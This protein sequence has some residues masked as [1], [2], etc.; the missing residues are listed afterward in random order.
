MKIRKS[1]L[2]EE[3]RNYKLQLQLWN[4]KIF[5]LQDFLFFRLLSI[6]FVYHQYDITR[7]HIHLY[8]VEKLSIHHTFY[9]T[10]YRYHSVSG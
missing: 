8:Y 9:I 7:I 4:I 2:H 1:K 5:S 3:N 10:L 6:I